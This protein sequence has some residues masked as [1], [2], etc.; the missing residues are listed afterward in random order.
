MNWTTSP[1]TTAV[2][3]PWTA[4]LAICCHVFAVFTNMLETQI[5]IICIQEETPYFSEILV[6][7]LCAADRL[8]K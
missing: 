8:C 6:W 4:E 1:N 5:Y 3:C 7:V 2:V